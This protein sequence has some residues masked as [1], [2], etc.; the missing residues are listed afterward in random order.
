MV[1]IIRD[2]FYFSLLI[3][4]IYLFA[5][6]EKYSSRYWPEVLK[7]SNIHL[8]SADSIVFQSD[9]TLIPVNYIGSIDF[10]LVDPDK[11]KD[12]FIMHLLP[13]I[14]ITRELLLD[15]M[16]HVEFIE[17][18]I[19]EKKTISEFDSTFLAKMKLKYD[20]DSL[21]ELKKRIYPQPISLALSQAVLESGWG[22]SNI[23]RNGNNIFGVMSF[24]SEEPRSLIHYQEGDDERYLRTYKT[25]LES[26]ENYFLLVSTVSSYK[27]FRQ[28]RWEGSTS[29]QL[30]RYMGR[31]HEDDQYAEM[32]QSIIASNNLEKYDN[33]VID[34]E[35]RE[36]L[37]LGSYL[38]KF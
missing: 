1:R 12:L 36:N 23:F 9:S 5:K 27:K 34:P 8:T 3:F 10:R 38:I 30:V 7:I 18:R 33:L 21:N 37:T 26:V 28:K 20:T 15:D 4:A 24:S 6:V 22:T 16:H 17:A 29:S 2:I 35:Y 11:R 19:K 14:L 13:A 25:V 32:A 31:Y